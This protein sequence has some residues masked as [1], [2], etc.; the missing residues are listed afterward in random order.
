M[1]SERNKVSWAKGNR[2]RRASGRTA[3]RALLIFVRGEL[4]FCHVLRLLCPLVC[5]NILLSI[6]K[7]SSRIFCYPSIEMDH[8]SK[9]I[10]ATYNRDNPQPVPL[11]SSKHSTERSDNQRPGSSGNHDYQALRLRV[12]AMEPAFLSQ[13]SDQGE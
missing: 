13:D 5:I 7:F 11:S 1:R 12:L 9:H 4:V 2:R 3:F 10:H 8:T 6:R